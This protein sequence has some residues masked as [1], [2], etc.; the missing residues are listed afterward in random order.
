MSK[1]LRRALL[2]KYWSIGER[3]MET[4]VVLANPP[5]LGTLAAS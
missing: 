4:S 5:L 1:T 2:E 3:Q